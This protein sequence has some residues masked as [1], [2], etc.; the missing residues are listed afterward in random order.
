M[1]VHT[2]PVARALLAMGHR[3]R[4]VVDLCAGELENQARSAQEAFLLKK[5]KHVVVCIEVNSQWQRLVHP[6]SSKPHPKSQ[7]P[8]A[9]PFATGIRP[10][11]FCEHLAAQLPKLACYLKEKPKKGR[12]KC[13]VLDIN[14]CHVFYITPKPVV[15]Q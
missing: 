14:G 12:V 4:E 9:I 2:N 6:D 5:K 10:E 3:R 1:S 11:S 8:N 13:I 15:L 7:D